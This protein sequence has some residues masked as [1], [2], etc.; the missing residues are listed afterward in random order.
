MHSKL[1]DWKNGWFGVEIGVKPTDI[2]ALI[3]NL[4][5]LREEPDQHFHLSSNYKGEGGLGDIVFYVQASGDPDNMESFGKALA[6]GATIPDLAPNQ[7]A[8]PTV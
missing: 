7:S 3:A 6:P 4:N 2:D 1:E 8:D 5:M